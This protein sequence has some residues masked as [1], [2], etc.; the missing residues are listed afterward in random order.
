MG[1]EAC[2]SDTGVQTGG[3]LAYFPWLLSQGLCCIPAGQGA[4]LG[5]SRL[6]QLAVGGHGCCGP[7]PAG[8]WVWQCPGPWCSWAEHMVLRTQCADTALDICARRRCHLPTGQVGSARPFLE[9]KRAAWSH[10]QGQGRLVAWSV[11]TTFLFSGR[12]GGA[13]DG[14]ERPG[15]SG[16]L[17]WVALVWEAVV[18]PP[19]SS[20]NPLA[21]NLR[22]RCLSP[23]GGRRRCWIHIYWHPFFYLGMDLGSGAWFSTLGHGCLLLFPYLPS[24]VT[25]CARPSE[26]APHRAGQ[27]PGRQWFHS[28]E[29]ADEPCWALAHSG[30]R[31][32]HL[33]GPS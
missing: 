16:E 24:S 6:C 32:S 27:P 3:S 30:R 17:A 28:A 5:L 11:L 8:A 2:L 18:L 7:E 23:L 20:L 29:G 22:A 14:D 19:R 1:F 9:L 13:V 21:G 12:G 33:P 4:T 10:R 25:L 31:C 26:S 15:L